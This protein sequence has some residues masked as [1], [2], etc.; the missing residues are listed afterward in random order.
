MAL[1]F[2]P[3]ELI[4][5]HDSE[6]RLS[7]VDTVDG[8]EIRRS[9]V[10][11]GSLSRNLEDFIHPRWLLGISSINSRSAAYLLEN[12]PIPPPPPPDEKD[13]TNHF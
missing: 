9:P 8:S 2:R 5:V 4:F 11:V 6:I 12:I 7:A 10:E 13:D 3:K 1:S